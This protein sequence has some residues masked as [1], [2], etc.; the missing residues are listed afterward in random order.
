VATVRKPSALDDL[1]EGYTQPGVINMAK[2]AGMMRIPPSSLRRGKLNRARAAVLSVK[3]SAGLRQFI[4]FPIWWPRRSKT[5]RPERN[6]RH[7]VGA[8]RAASEPGHI[9]AATSVPAPSGYPP[10]FASTALYSIT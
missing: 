3:G 9:R 8:L 7:L 1:K 10:W 4:R 2:P 6:N 5:G